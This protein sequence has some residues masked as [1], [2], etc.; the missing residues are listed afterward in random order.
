MSE[1]SN[2]EFYRDYYIAYNTKRYA[3]RK[4]EGICVRCGKAKALEGKTR[5]DACGEIERQRRR[6]QRRER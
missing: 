4:A 2:Y 6:K 5:C 3:R 1:K